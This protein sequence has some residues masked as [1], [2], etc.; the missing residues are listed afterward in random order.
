M[1]HSTA[2]AMGRSDLLANGISQALLTTA[3][4]LSVAIPAMA[5]YLFFVGRVDRLIIEIDG[6]G[7]IEG[8]MAVESP[9]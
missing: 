7:H 8:V 2:A 1:Y 6:L 4:G 5:A 9:A 3:A